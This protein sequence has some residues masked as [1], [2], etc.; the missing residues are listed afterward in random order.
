MEWFIRT[1][2]VNVAKTKIS[3]SK[4]LRIG[5]TGSY[6]KTSVKEMLQTILSQKFR[7]L[8]TPSSYNTPMG[9]ALAVKKLDSTHDI[10]I[11]EMGARAKGDIRDLC[12]IVKPNIGV[13]TGINSQ[14]LETF[15]NIENTKNTKYELFENLAH[16]GVGF[17]S[18]DNEHTLE[19]SNRFSNEKHLAGIS[20]SNSL[21][22]AT[23]IVIDGKGTTFMLCIKGEEPVKCRTVLLGKHSI[24]NICLASAVAYKLGMTKEEIS[25]GI[26]RIQSIDHRLEL[27][28]NNKN[29]V[30][31]DDSYNSNA[32]GVK[33][34]MEVLDLFEGRKII[35][36]PGLVELGSQE[37]IANFEMGKLLSKHAD[38]V[39][40]IGKHNAETLINGLIEGGF[41]RENIR[42]AKSLKKGN[43]QL[44]EI[45]TEGDVVLFENDLPD[46]Y[47]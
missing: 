31:I 6:G 36:T 16:G 27:M 46:N 35:L 44:N 10:F 34:A 47:N 32:D 33:A 40:V 14:H 45:L 24:S 22:S 42:F 20:D 2:Y 18:S 43:E 25:Q 17:F 30:I 23:D 4:V 9:I 29:I 11:A 15:G 8:A 26:N 7:V 41:N 21:V 13:V 28:P 5:I 19:I 38:M 12:Q 39:F 3:K 37:N 1:H